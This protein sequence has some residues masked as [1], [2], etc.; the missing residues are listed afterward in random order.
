M[1]AATAAMILFLVIGAMR[2]RRE[3]D[4]S[5]RIVLSVGLLLLTFY[6]AIVNRADSAHIVP[7]AAV[8]IS[9]FPILALPLL[10]ERGDGRVGS[11]KR[12][13][14]G[15]LTLF[16]SL[17]FAHVA[18]LGLREDARIVSGRE[19]S[20]EV[21]AQPGRSFRVDSPTVARDLNRLLPV[22]ER[23]ATSGSSLFVG[24]RDLR[25]TNYNDAFVY[26]LLPKLKP[27]SFYLELNPGTA[28]DQ[29][30]VSRTT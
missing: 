23:A 16:S 28:T 3:G 17:A 14:I 5:A 4:I 6:P 7:V 22:I 27:A 12:V 9:L 15:L 24:P 19:R 2:M 18:L 11:A 10:H 26:Y 21:R 25:R 30:R 13:G 29:A 20:F 1:V 8:A